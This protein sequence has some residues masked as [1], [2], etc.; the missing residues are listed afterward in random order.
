MKEMID[1]RQT[2][3][4]ERNK[5]LFSQERGGTMLT[6]RCSKKQPGK[7]AAS[8]FSIFS[9]SP[10]AFGFLPLAFLF[11]CA[12]YAE[13]GDPGNNIK[14]SSDHIHN[15]GVVL[16]K[17]ETVEQ[18]PMLTAPATVVV[19][20][21]HEYLVSASQAGLITRLNASIGER[22]KQGDVLAELNSPD[23]L[24]L[25]RLYLKA[26]NELQLALL[27]YR[28]DKKLFE[29]GV[30]AERRWQE[31]SSQYN[32]IAS[33]ANEHRQ[34]LKIAGM[35]DD[36][37]RRLKSSHRLSSRLNVLSPLSGTVMERIGVA[38][39]RVD[40]LAPLY[41]IANLEQLWLEISIPQE[42][43]AQ[44]KIGDGILVE[45]LVD[46]TPNTEKSSIESQAGITAK[47]SMV[48]Q[49][50]NPNNQTVMARA[51]IDG[52]PSLIRPGQRITIQIVQGTPQTAFKVP[53]TAIAQNEGKYYLF[54][55]NQD[56]FRVIPVTVLGKET[57]ESVIRGDL[58]GAEEIAVKG[59]VA[60]KANWLGLG[61]GE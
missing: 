32:A 45:A 5:V 49:T 6:P 10:F 58:T 11:A 50:V 22:V 52:G 25:Q 14:L 18:N 51:I 20:P 54:A 29:E 19:P 21:A 57:E 8:G 33:E 40:I 16:G 27:S 46:G 37:I 13:S 42:R 12:S 38:G 9:P 61:N 15:L 44:V 43:A 41:R 24:S 60:L 3:Q 17:L 7:Q 26:E 31:T 59:A 53:H 34:L 1:L 28:R 35:R 55:R 23:L 2:A 47:I 56:G 39:S 36:E 4:G 48:S 30:I